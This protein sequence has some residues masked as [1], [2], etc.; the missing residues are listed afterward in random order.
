MIVI[1]TLCLNRTYARMRCPSWKWTNWS[2]S[3]RTLQPREKSK[4]IVSFLMASILHHWRHLLSFFSH[5]D[6]SSRF[7]FFEQITLVSTINWWF[8]PRSMYR[9]RGKK[10]FI[11]KTLFFSLVQMK[12][13]DP[14]K[15][16]EF[17]LLFVPS[18]LSN[19]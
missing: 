4:G 8:G 18:G 17:D 15:M 14:D 12:K 3:V 1:F 11:W 6:F 13:C 7:I 16:Y 10:T 2:Y 19:F 9:S 5:Y